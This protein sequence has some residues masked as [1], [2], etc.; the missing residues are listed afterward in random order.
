MSEKGAD[1]LLGVADAIGALMEFW[2]FKR[3]MGRL[4]CVLYLSPHPLSAAELASRLGLSSGAISM[5][6]SSLGRWHA[7]EKTSIP[8]ERR[9]YFRAETDIWKMVS[10]VFRERELEQIKR[11]ITALRT[12]ESAL[13]GGDADADDVH[14]LSQIEGLLQ[15][16]NIGEHLLE[17]ILSG[18][19]ID[20]AALASFAGPRDAE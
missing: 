8:G 18:E 4:W 3:N 10:N 6:L 20:A 7:I 9:D 5:T 11:A 1:P 14:A 19:A 15:L 13:R 16:A 17:T 12:A 2:G